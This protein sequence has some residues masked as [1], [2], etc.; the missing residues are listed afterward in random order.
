MEVPSSAVKTPS[1]VVY[2]K[3]NPAPRPIGEYPG[4]FVKHNGIYLVLP[5]GSVA[6]L[7]TT[8]SDLTRVMKLLYGSVSPIPRIDGTAFYLAGAG[9]SKPQD[10]YDSTG[11]RFLGI[12][13]EKDPTE[14]P[15][16]EL[17]P[18][19]YGLILRTFEAVA[20]THTS[21]GAALSMAFYPDMFE[22]N[23]EERCAILKRSFER[24]VKKF[25][26]DDPGSLTQKLGVSQVWILIPDREYAKAVSE[27]FSCEEPQQSRGL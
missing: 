15:Q 9:F 24:A 14:V 27:A 22:G 19:L 4:C 12:K 21:P 26:G 16:S 8:I 25:A 20:G 3:A 17:E 18:Y 13:C 7:H 11:I 6:A 5:A 23:T 10:C 1:I 2:D